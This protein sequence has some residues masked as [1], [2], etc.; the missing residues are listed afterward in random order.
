VWLLY[1]IQIRDGSRRCARGWNLLQHSGT[2][3][4]AVGASE[5]SMVKGKKRTVRREWTAQDVRELKK[6]SK[7]KTPVNAIAKA[8]K[9]TP[10][11]VRQKAT[12]LGIS[13]GHRR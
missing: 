9:R 8:M 7:S 3:E 11:A 6:H 10:G 4:E 13:I 12:S 1:T 2:P 5:E